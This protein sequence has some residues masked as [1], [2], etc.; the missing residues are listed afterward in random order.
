MVTRSGARR[1]V[2]QYRLNGNSERL[3]LKPG[4]T[5]KEARHEARKHL[6]EVAKG[7]SPL[8][9]RRKNKLVS[10][11][12]VAAIAAEYFQRDGKRLRS[13][14]W[15]QAALSCDGQARA[16]TEIARGSSVR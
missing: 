5:L 7:N 6:G 1:F 4:L 11:N 15:Q 9:E 16:P 12:T 8:A 3:T 2:L 10:A 14:N 13:A